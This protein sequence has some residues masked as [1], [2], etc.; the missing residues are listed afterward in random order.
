MP[1]YDDLLQVGVSK[2]EKDTIMLW[3]YH[4]KDWVF[5][6][7]YYIDFY[8]IQHQLYLTITARNITYDY[9]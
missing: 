9:Q 5:V 7:V 4:K 2:Y 3:V 6:L 8:N 1:K